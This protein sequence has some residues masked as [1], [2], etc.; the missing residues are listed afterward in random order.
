MACQVLPRFATWLQ[1][2]E[3]R[4]FEVCVFMSVCRSFSLCC[5]QGNEVHSTTVRQSILFAVEPLSLRCW[6][7]CLVF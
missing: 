6:S 4:L 1:D 7:L 5:V 3:F 2:S